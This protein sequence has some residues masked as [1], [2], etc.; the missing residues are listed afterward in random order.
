MTRCDDSMPK[1]MEN[2]KRKQTIKN[3]YVVGNL[4][5][6]DTRH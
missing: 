6:S 1:H 5:T 2:V 4:H 3:V